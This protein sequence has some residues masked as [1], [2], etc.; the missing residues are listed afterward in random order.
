MTR[1]RTALALAAATLALAACAEPQTPEAP[2]TGADELVIGLT[3]TPDVQFAPFYVAEERGYY[4]DAG[5]D[6]TLR[7]HGASES[8]LGALEAGEEDL[9][10]AGGDEMLQARSAGVP[11]VTVATLYEE[12]PV[13]LIVPADSDITTAADLAGHSVGIPG[14]FGETYFGLLALLGNAGLSEEDVTVESIGYTQ[15]AA[16]SAGHVDAV[17]GFANNDAVRFAQ[18][19][20]DVRTIP[21]GD[22]PLVGIGIGAHEDIADDGATAA[23]VEATMRGVRDVVEDPAAAVEIAAEHVPGLAD[24]A[25]REAAMATVEATV[26]LYGSATGTNDPALWEA[27]ATFMAEQGLLEGEVAA[28]DAVRALG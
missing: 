28:A 6:V 12:Y 8:L 25:A 4:E 26:P 23:V 3:Y 2:T 27:M 24:P 11:V 22:V 16:L 18:A 21:L 14:P 19:G 10:V 7:H 1:R 20:V 17:M 15:Q 9:V 13:V 5:V